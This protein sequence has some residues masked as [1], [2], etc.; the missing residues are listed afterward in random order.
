MRFTVA[1]D[2]TFHA[3]HKLPDHDGK[4]KELHGH[5]YRCR[6]SVRGPLIEHGPK[7][8][9]VIDFGDLSEIWREECEPLLDHKYLNDTLPVP[10]T[11]AELIAGWILMRF[12]DH[13]GPYPGIA[14]TVWETPTSWARAS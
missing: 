8:G 13:L 1:K 9:M 14:V 3:A 6:V 7:A 5:T 2:W 12:R 10:Q 11:T 4:C